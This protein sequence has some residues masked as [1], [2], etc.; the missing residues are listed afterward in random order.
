ME[1]TNQTTCPRCSQK[2]DFTIIDLLPMIPFENNKMKCLRC[3]KFWNLPEGFE[4]G[5]RT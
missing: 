2:K 3:G 1:L 4:H 5:N